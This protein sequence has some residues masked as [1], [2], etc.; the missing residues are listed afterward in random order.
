MTICRRTGA[1]ARPRTRSRSC[2]ADWSISDPEVV[3]SSAEATPAWHPVPECLHHARG[4]HA[5]ALERGV[6]ENHGEV[7][8]TDARGD[9]ADAQTG[10]QQL[11]DDQ[12]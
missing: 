6:G 4:E 9:V 7:V 10:E 5:R 12:Q 2:A 3:S 8:V 1:Y 11:G